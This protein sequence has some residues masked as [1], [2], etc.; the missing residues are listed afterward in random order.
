LFRYLASRRSVVLLGESH[1]DVR[2]HLWQLYA[3]SALYGRGANVVIGF[4]AFPRRL[5]PVLNDWVEGKLTDEAFLKAIEWQQVWGY[6]AALYMPLFQFARMSH[7]PMIALNVDWKLVSQVGQLGW[8]NVPVGEREGLSDPAPAS[9]GYLHHLAGA[10]LTKRTVPH[11]GTDHVGQ[12]PDF[13]EPNETALNQAMKE[14][15]FKR[16]VEAQLT[17]DRAMAEALV[18]AKQNFGNALVVGILGIGHVAGGYGVPRQLWA[19]GGFEAS[20]LIPA[21]IGT[22]CALIGTG[23]ADAIFTLPHRSEVPLAALA[24]L[25][26]SLDERD[27]MP[28]INWVIN[29]SVAETAGLKA[30]DQVV[31]AAGLEMKKAEDLIE[32]VARQPPG[33]W[34][35]LSVRRDGQD[36][37]IVAR[38][39]PRP[40]AN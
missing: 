11:G 28:R 38:F 26:V 29:D 1:D 3:V 32:V 16:F 7:I 25:G 8:E 2:H 31:R 36:I 35:P 19:L 17:W 6:D 4:E 30:G 20:S 10:Y 33:T 37:D 39:P 24:Q 22:A 27:G 14:P 12:G 13:P 9:I 40:K 5:Q 15:E 23:Y 18:Q 34:L 21:T